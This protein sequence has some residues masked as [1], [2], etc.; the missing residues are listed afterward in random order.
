MVLPLV[1]LS[2]RGFGESA[3]GLWGELVSGEVSLP[4]SLPAASPED[5]DGE[6]PAWAGSE[7]C[8]G[9]RTTPGSTVQEV[10]VKIMFLFTVTGSSSP[11]V[12]GRDPE[13]YN[14]QEK[15]GGVCGG[16]GGWGGGED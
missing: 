11:C 12:G 13:D 16:G 5:Q 1:S 6:R 8:A 3:V 2:V 9:S 14:R 10:R 7:G 15:M 4:P